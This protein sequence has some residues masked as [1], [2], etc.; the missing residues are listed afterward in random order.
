MSSDGPGGFPDLSGTEAT[1]DT[2]HAYSRVLGAVRRAHAP[3]HPRWWHVSLG[4]GPRGLVMPTTPWPGREDGE[5]GMY[6]DLVDHQLKAV[7]ADET[8]A[9]ID[10]R[11]GLSASALGDRVIHSLHTVGVDVAPER[12]RYADDTTE[13]YDPEHAGAWLAALQAAER[14]L[15]TVRE[16]LDGERGPIQLWPHHFDLSFECFGTRRVTYVEDGEEREA[17][18]QIGCGFSPIPTAV[19]GGKPYFYATPWPFDD[20]LAHEMLP[21]DAAWVTEGWQGALLPYEEARAR[22]EG[23]VKEFCIAVYELTRSRLD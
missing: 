13:M 14:A 20:A 21:S 12:D 5:F 23:A 19:G 18:S 17:T 11:E 4:I 7:V 1:R 6:L 3:A 2:L 10:L 15:G 22:G 8:V 9:S 16:D